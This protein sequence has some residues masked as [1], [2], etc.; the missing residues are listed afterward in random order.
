LHTRVANSKNAL[1][2]I[3]ADFDA[4]IAKLEQQHLKT[5]QKI[6]NAKALRARLEIEP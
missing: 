3:K 2:T 4:Q 6:A 1:A 5:A